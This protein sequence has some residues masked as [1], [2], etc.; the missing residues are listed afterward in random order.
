[1]NDNPKNVF[2]PLIVQQLVFLFLN[3]NDRN[4]AKD[5]DQKLTYTRI[6][7]NKQVWMDP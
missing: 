6:S 1:M 3:D 5:P 4:S 2:S 7:Q